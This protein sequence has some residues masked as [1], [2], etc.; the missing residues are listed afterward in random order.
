MYYTYPLVYR[1]VGCKDVRWYFIMDNTGGIKYAD[2]DLKRTGFDMFPKYYMYDTTA[3]YSD[4]E[5]K[6][7]NTA[8]YIFD[9]DNL[10]I[11]DKSKLP[12]NFIVS[13][14]NRLKKTCWVY[15]NGEKRINPADPQICTPDKC[16]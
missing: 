13:K 9:N 16:Y 3:I 12:T 10:K 1:Q 8:N 11:N 14:D 2:E 7:P 4:I 5:Y 6:L 15:S